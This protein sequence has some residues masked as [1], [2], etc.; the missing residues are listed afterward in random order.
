M[1]ILASGASFALDL[2][3]RA[4][5]IFAATGAALY[6][7]RRG[8]ATTRHGVGTL[9]LGAALALPVLSVV[10]PRV[11]V[12][13]LSPFA[14]RVGPAGTPAWVRM[15][16]LFWAVGSLAVAVRL[17]AGWARV[18]RLS[19]DAA[20]V[21]DA[22][23]IADRDTAARRLALSRAVDLRETGGIAM[24]VT[25]GWRRPLL[26]VG[27]AA[28]LWAADRR[29]VVLLHELAHIKR[30][31]WPALLMAE[32]AVALYWFHPLALWLGRRVRR[33]AE[34]ACDELVIGTGTKPSVYAAH[35]LGLFRSAGAAPLPAS[36]ALAIARPHHFEERLRAILEP[37]PAALAPALPRA[38]LA[39]AGLFAAAALATFVSPWKP[40]GLPAAPAAVAARTGCARPPC[41][42]SAA[43]ALPAAAVAPAEEAEPS[44]DEAPAEIPGAVPAI[45]NVDESARSPEAG[46]VKASNSRRTPRDGDDWYDRGMQLHR[47]ERYTEA[48]AAFQKAIEEGYREDAASYNIACGYALL[49]DQDK[50]FE[51]LHRAMDEGFDVAAYMRSDDD[52]DTLHSDARWGE[53]RAAARAEKSNAEKAEA[54]S[55]TNRYERIVTKAPKSGESFFDVGR[56]LLHVDRYDLAAKA[57]QAAIE[58]D[59]RVGTAY[60]NQA[61]AFSLDGKKDAALEALQR[62]LDAGFD[63]PD[64]FE[65]DDDLDAVRSDP[66]F[67]ALAQ[68][69]EDL[70]LPG[71]GNGW[72][73][74]R[75]RSARAHWRADVKKFSAY[76]EK[77][78]KSGRAWFNL[79][80]A[81]LAADRPQDA[82]PAFQKALDLGYRRPTTMYNLACSYSRLDQKDAAF[83][84]LFKALDAGFDENWTLKTDD[85][86][87]N[88]RSDSRYRKAVQIAR[89]N[90][91]DDKD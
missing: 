15:A 12:P 52:L 2:A 67:A 31:D 14:A 21:R 7:L 11:S 32:L 68:E 83:D 70:S 80:Y 59:Y 18:R 4:T 45:W 8:S 74:G 86:L 36:P 48:I 84:W 82:T 77:H 81:S 87:D 24:A 88:L 33:D 72:W 40:A 37:R 6:A 57:Y 55:V 63:Q 27:R 79:G 26:L 13:L 30:G 54:R 64:L 20:P 60:Y 69:A 61:C 25:S 75:S 66:R 29:R 91:R 47:R 34:Q 17:A 78:P 90:D 43:Q 28:R 39:T 51:W 22:E 49:G 1:S 89:A 10:L 58:R 53:L 56:Q 46:F 16:L 50:A 85:D 41:P 65:N 9:G 23:W 76:A 3:L 71:Y 19:R 42:R 73:G 5:V 62:A 44:S 35:L 38:H